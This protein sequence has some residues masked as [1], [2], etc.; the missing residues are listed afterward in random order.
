MYSPATGLSSG[1]PCQEELETTFPTPEDPW[2]T[3]LLLVLGA[4]L[5]LG[6]ARGR[7]SCQVENVGY[8]KLVASTIQNENNQFQYKFMTNLFDYTRT[9][10]LPFEE[11]SNSPFYAN[12]VCFSNCDR[13]VGSFPKP[14]NWRVPLP[15][16][17]FSTCE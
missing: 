14:C 8:D 15:I 17:K 7:R 3:L 9:T 16:S 6:R 13:D 4:L 5:R 2:S 10:D 11:Q 1:P 12:L